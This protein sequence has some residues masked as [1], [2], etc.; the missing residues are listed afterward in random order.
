MLLKSERRGVFTARLTLLFVPQ[1]CAVTGAAYS[2]KR[3]A[4]EGLIEV[5][6]EVAIHFH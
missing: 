3:L 6:I 5:N 1:A 4:G 2:R